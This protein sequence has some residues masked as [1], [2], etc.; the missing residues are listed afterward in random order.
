MR[1]DAD[2]GD[3]P[4]VDLASGRGDSLGRGSDESPTR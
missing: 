2:S 3:V 1:Y 4:S